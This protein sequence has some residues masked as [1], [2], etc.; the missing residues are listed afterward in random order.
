V[1]RDKTHLIVEID[2]LRDQ[3]IG[4]Q[5]LLRGLT[6]EFRADHGISSHTSLGNY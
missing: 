5:M 2:L 6:L 4:L 3:L 1:A